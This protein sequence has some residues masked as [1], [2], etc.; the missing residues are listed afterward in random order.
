M[1]YDQAI[2]RV[3]GTLEEAL[4]CAFWKW[5][6]RNL[7]GAGDPLT[8]QAVANAAVQFRERQ[9]AKTEGLTGSR[10]NA[11]TREAL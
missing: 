10:R 4:E 11:E 7:L 2:R 3:P 8:W 5:S 1:T 6:G 9:Q